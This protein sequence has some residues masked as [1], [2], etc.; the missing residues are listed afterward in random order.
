MGVGVSGERGEERITSLQS[1]SFFSMAS[2]S[3]SSFLL[4]ASSPKEL[5]CRVRRAFSCE[6]ISFEAEAL[7]LP[8][9]CTQTRGQAMRTSWGQQASPPLVVP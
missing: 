2:S 7:G 9:T 1:T 8:R 5:C 4:S 6:F 3:S